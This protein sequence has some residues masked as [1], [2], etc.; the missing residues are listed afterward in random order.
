MG[1]T[2]CKQ[3]DYNAYGINETEAFNSMLNI[4]LR[5]DYEVFQSQTGY[6]GQQTPV[7]LVTEPLN[8]FGYI[9]I[10]YYGLYRVVYS[11]TDN[12]LIRARLHYVG[13]NNCI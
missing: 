11:T 9:Y 6:S 8:P 2:L 7:S 1:C 4:L 5:S 3:L 12:D 13:P 10:R